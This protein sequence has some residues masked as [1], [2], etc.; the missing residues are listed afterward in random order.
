MALDT[1]QLGRKGWGILIT[2]AVA[3]IS[4]FLPWY[5]ASVAGYTAQSVNAWSTGYGWIAA[6]LLVA[7]SVYLFIRLQGDVKLPAR[8]AAVVLVLSALGLLLVFIRLGSLPTGSDNI[9]GVATYQYGGRIG[10]VIALLAGL[11][12][13]VCAALLLRSARRHPG[14]EQTA[15]AVPTNP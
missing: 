7:A 5:G 10:I 14:H 4:L 8:S 2:G 11:V 12:Q 9:A 15:P 6:G 13:V 1:K 3:F